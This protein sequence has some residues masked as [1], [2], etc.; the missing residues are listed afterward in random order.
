MNKEKQKTLVAIAAHADDAELNAGG[1]MAKWIA[2][3]GQVHILMVT[4][5]CSGLLI[6]DN[7][8]ETRLYRA[9]PAETTALRHREQT[10]AAAVIGAHV[11]FLNFCQRHF[12]DGANEQTLN[13]SQPPTPFSEINQA[14]PL[15]IAADEPATHA[16]LTQQLIDLDPDLVLTHPP[17]DLD[18]EHQTVASIIWRI[19][20]Q[21][22]NLRASVP[23]RFWA[24]G[25]SCPAGMLPM[26][27]D[28]I[29]DISAYYS[30][31]QAQLRCHRSQMTRDRW[32]RTD[33]RS[34][35]F[36]KKI[37]VARAEPFFTVHFA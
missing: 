19:F 33:E 8:D 32:N 1:T 28:H 25:G 27:Y 5:N 30:A 2:D 14:Q 9:G 37:N 24:P 36:G 20:Q 34:R 15:L 7:G 6:P 29:E 22:K 21:N 11:H 10:A 18:P 31:K 3:G 16:R 17:V 23:L 13:F 12:F 26:N 35:F 4:N